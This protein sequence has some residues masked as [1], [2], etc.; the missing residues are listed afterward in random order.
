MSQKSEVVVRRAGRDD[1]GAIA[2]LEKEVYGGLGTACYGLEYAEAWLETNPEGLFVAEA[3][4]EVVGYL[5][6]Q[7]TQFG[8]DILDRF[9]DYDLVTDHGY[10]RQSH[11]PSGNCV[12][13]V[14]MCSKS[15]GAGWALIRESDEYG[16]K[17]GRRYYL[18]LSR[19]P[20]LDSY[21]KKVESLSGP[22]DAKTAAKVALHYAIETV[23]S[24]NAHIWVEDSPEIVITLPELCDPDPVV[25][26]HARTPGA[27][28]VAVLENCMRDPGSRNF[29]A[30]L[31]R[32]TPENK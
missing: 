14:T 21:L 32:E 16:R 17:T 25:R 2:G 20:G 1:L 7:V 18:G 13:V 3:D 22:L 11:D 28:L 19:M 24:V 30:L 29:A 6:C 23:R 4:G 5:Y 31:V 12:Q 26:K 27:G 10:T 9:R 8:F 15:A